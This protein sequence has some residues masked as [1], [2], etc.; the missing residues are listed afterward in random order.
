MQLG[1]IGLG[2]MGGNM[3]QRLIESGHA[4]VGHDTSAE[5]RAEAESRG[6]RAAE[7]LAALA[8]ALEPPR[9]IWIMVP[10][11]DPV[12]QTIDG[13]LPHLSAG[14]VLVDGGNSRWT[15]AAFRAEALE[16]HG[17]AFLDVGTSGGIWGLA[18]GYCLMVGGGHAAFGRLE[19][20]LAALAPPGGYAH[21]GPSGAGHFV[22]MVHNAVEYGMLQAFGEGFEMLH[23]SPLGIDLPS[24]AELWRHGSV[25]RSWLLDLAARA[26]AGDPRLDAV[27]GYVEDSGE[28]RWS[29]E[30]AIDHAVPAPV[31]AQSL[32]ARFASRQEDSFSAKV[33]AALR[34]EFGGHAVHRREGAT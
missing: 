21:V 6:G 20:I 24:V 5:K 23:A 7:T 9:A 16:R 8:A 17:I 25:V 22:K 19:P 18:E 11:G 29:L 31:L 15:E 2:R 32:F 14:D 13:L 34:N 4:V 1:I 27:R 28:G 12:T 26:F 10:H 33:I 30:Y 3:L